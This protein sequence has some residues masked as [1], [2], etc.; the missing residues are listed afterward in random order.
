VLTEGAAVVGIDVAPDVGIE[1]AGDRGEGI[2]CVGA[3]GGIAC[4]GG[5]AAPGVAAVDAGC[6]PV[7]GPPGGRMM[8]RSSSSGFMQLV[9]PRRA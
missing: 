1:V 7:R 9:P 2:V 3:N 5:Y 4:V 8:V 6:C